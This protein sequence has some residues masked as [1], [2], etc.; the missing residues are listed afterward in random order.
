MNAKA[1]MVATNLDIYQRP[2]TARW[3]ATLNGLVPAEEAALAATREVWQGGDV[4]DIGIGGGRTSPHLAPQA[5]SYTGVDYS[6]AMVAVA[7]QRHPHLDVRQ[8]DARD[9]SVFPD[10]SFDFAL[11]PDNGIDA[12]DAPGR[13]RILAEVRRVLR[14]GGVFVFNAHNLDWS[15]NGKIWRD[16]F[17]VRLSRSPIST[18]KAFARIPIRLWNYLRTLRRKVSTESYVI[19]HDPGND[20]ASPHYY[21]GAV[22]MKR[23]LQAAGFALLMVLNAQGVETSHAPEQESATLHYVVRKPAA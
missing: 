18:A 10:A 20:F 9:L 4:L 12:V 21:T 5:R 16:M 2:A 17:S 3:Y 1:D 11:F 15:E 19:M 8:A 14:P 13:G 7:R 23:Q 6:P 22:E